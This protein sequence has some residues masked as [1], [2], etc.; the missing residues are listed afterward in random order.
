MS[1]VIVDGRGANVL[2]NKPRNGLKHDQTQSGSPIFS[3]RSA[4]NEVRNEGGYSGRVGNILRPIDALNTAAVGGPAAVKGRKL[5]SGADSD[6]S[7]RDEGRRCEGQ[8]P[9]YTR[10]TRCTEAASRR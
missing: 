7:E 3:R 5:K 2:S 4:G 8:S 1:S 10:S 9:F 6:S